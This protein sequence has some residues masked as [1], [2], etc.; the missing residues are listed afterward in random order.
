MTPPTTAPTGPATLPIT[1][2]AAV[3]AACL[4]IGGIEMLSDELPLFSDDW[5]FSSSGIR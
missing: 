4:E 1:A 5:V 2:P 3:P